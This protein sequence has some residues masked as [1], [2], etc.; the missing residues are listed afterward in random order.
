MEKNLDKQVVMRVSTTSI[1]VNCVLSLLKLIAGIIAHSGAMISDA[2]HSASDVFSTII[3]II[4]VNISHRD[5]DQDHQYGHERMECI[6]SILLAAV[7][8]LTGGGIGLSGIKKITAGQYD[9]L[10]IPGSLAL[11]AAVISIVVKEWMYWY[12]RAAAKK[13]NSTALMADAWHHRSDSLSSVGS[14]I[15]IF[16]ARLGWPV[17]DPIASVVIC[18]FIIKAAYDIGKDALDKMVDHSCDEETEE[19]IRQVILEQEGVIR[20]D[21]LK[22]RLFGSKIYVDVEIA[23]DGNLKLIDSHAIAEA[24]HDAIEEKFS[25][26]KHCMVHVNPD[27]INSDTE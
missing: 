15:G 22:T 17:L 14:F 16:G 12:T 20:I 4:G 23:A 11:I 18:L 9:Q 3:V 1:I 13:I 5:S 6:A 24:V 25:T 10:A 27:M 2:V 21:E 26:V 8:A 7:L 19:A